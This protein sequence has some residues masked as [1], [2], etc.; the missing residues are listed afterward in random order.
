MIAKEYT[1]AEIC[2]RLSSGKAIK[3]EQICSTGQFPVFGGNGVRGYTNNYN[4]NGECA[5]IGRQGAYCGNVNFFKGMAYMTEHAV[6]VCGNEKCNTKFLSFVLQRMNLGHLSH[7]AAQPGLS[8]KILGEQKISLPSIEIQNKIADILSKYDNLI[9]NN[10]KQIKLLEEAAQRLYKEWFVDLHFPGYENATITDRVPEGWNKCTL[11]EIVPILTGKK[12]ANFGTADG[13][14][15][16]FTCSQEPIK[17]PSYSFDT[18]AVILAGNGDFNVKLY[19]GK[20]EAYQ[21]TYVLSPNDLKHLYL[22]YHAVNSN[23]NKLVKGASGSTIKFLTKGMI[24]SI[25]ILIPTESVLLQFNQLMEE[26][27]CKIEVLKKSMLLSTEAR[28]RLLPKLMSGEI[29]V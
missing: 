16:F 13:Q 9:E 23:M 20:F 8:V 10:Q 1:L 21:R 2:S 15:P 5:I 7:Q 29:E 12:D 4:F 18:S 11:G 6:V 27:Q 19:R 25:E 14:Y 28:D 3:A 17:A 22:L 26:I 24:E